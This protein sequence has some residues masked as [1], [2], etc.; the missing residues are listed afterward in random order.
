MTIT[1]AFRRPRARLRFHPDVWEEMISELARRGRGERESGAF[2]LSPRGDGRAVTRVEYLDDLDPASLVG[3]IHLHRSAYGHLWSLC[4][5]ESLRVVG[6]VHT[7]P[8]PNVQQSCVDRDNPMV[9]RT[10]HLAI[11][12]PNLANGRIRPEEIGVY[13]YLGESGWRSSLGRRAA[14]LVYVGRWA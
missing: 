14:R 5:R 6:D 2:L 13:E 8:G 10:G 3:S 12:L 4:D 7:H 9:A 11:I 1:R